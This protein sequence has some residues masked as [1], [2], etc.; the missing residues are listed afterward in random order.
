MKVRSSRPKSIENAAATM[1]DHLE[2][3]NERFIRFFPEL[4]NFVNEEMAKR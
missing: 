4:I 2:E 1:M 3:L